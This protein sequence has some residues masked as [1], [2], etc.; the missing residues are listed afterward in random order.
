MVISHAVWCFVFFL[1]LFFNFTILYSFC[2]ISTWI[3]HRYTHVLHPE[4]SSFLFPR[5]IPLG[6]P[7]APAPSVDEGHSGWC[8]VIS[9]WSFDLHFSNNLW[10]WASFPVPLVSIYLFWSDV[11]LGFP[12][13]FYW[14]F[15]FFLYWAQWAVRIFCRLFIC[16]LFHLQIFPPLLKVVFF[17]LFII[18]FVVQKLLGLIRSQ[19][20]ILFSLF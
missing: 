8:E 15:F 20:F 17:V 7:S 12:L 4:P 10:C 9:H 3:H 5:T 6:R 13:V 18:L 14:N 11:Y 1:I 2:H 16:L 19:F